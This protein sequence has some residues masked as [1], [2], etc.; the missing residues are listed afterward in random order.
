MVF[1][2]ALPCQVASLFH[3]PSST[4]FAD[5]TID[6]H[7]ETW[8]IRSRQFR[9][10]LRRRYFE[11]TGSAASAE[12]VRSALDLLEARAQF[13]AP[14]RMVHIRVA[15]YDDRI[16]LD[17]ADSDWRAI[18]IGPD[19]WQVVTSPPVRFRRAAGMLPLPVPQRGGSIEALAAFLN[20]P[21]PDEFVLVIAWLLAALQRGGPYPLLVI[22]GEQGSAKTVLT[23][24]LR[25]LIDPNAAPTRALP[26]EERDLMIAAN[27]G[28]ILAFD[29]LSGLPAWL[30][31][32][33][34]RLA[35]GGSFATRQ[36]YTDCD[37]VLFQAAR[38]AIL[39]GIEDIV[40]RSDL[41]D[42]AIFLTLEPIADERRRMER[43]L[44]REFE[45]ARPR[46][47][48]ALFDAAAQGLR[49]LSRVRLERL[50][51]MADF[52]LWAT[53]CE[54]A[55]W[56]P[57]TFLRVYDANRRAA[58]EGVIEA[59]PVAV[60]VREIMAVR[61]AWAGRASDL[62]RV[63]I[64][65]GEDVLDGTT[66]WPK[67]PRALAGRLR[68]CQT[69][70]RTVG[71]DI[72]FSREGRTGSRMIRITSLAKSPRTSVGNGRRLE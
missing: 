22:A 39:N 25:A 2:L 62:L 29:N 65:A 43:Q 56:P 41:A 57:G 28:H 66:G 31:D 70:L 26:R 69:F 67:N 50:P 36:L 33:L 54:T 20:L 15:E 63:H 4:A 7:R 13:D 11:E 1:P 68:R 71:I 16:Y 44:W 61:S 58:I 10:W 24:I 18:Q 34:C 48:G 14:E 37:E 59:D 52:A 51:R 5:L 3:D 12:T 60:F 47:L 53:A 64:A 30:S 35:S 45:V 9:H 46:I 38:P 40:C 23:R 6:G 49:G 19:G 17:L 27:N 55:F 21:A 42:R 8:P 72:A 32:A